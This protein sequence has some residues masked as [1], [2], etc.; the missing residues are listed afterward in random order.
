MRRSPVIAA[1]PYIVLRFFF[2]N[3]T[4]PAQR[5]RIGAAT[6]AESASLL[7]EVPSARW[8]EVVA[9]TWILASR[10]RAQP[11][12]IQRRSIAALGRGVDV[13]TIDSGH[14]VMLTHPE[15]LARTLLD[16]IR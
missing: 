2:G 10:D 16:V 11:P 9:S 3:G 1:V 13:R 8:P 7:S 12:S 6:C 14:E 4:T 15:K 5:T